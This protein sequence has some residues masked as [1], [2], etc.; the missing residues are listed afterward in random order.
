VLG[1]EVAELTA[2]EEVRLLELGKHDARRLV[3][4]SAFEANAEVGAV[5]LVEVPLGIE[6][7][8]ELRQRRVEVLAAVARIF[9]E[10]K[11]VLL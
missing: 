3:V 6:L 11:Y 10:L 2:D 8:L 4:L 1:R 7:A 9:V 5:E